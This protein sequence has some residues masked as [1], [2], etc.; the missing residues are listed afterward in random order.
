MFRSRESSTYRTEMGVH[1]EFIK[2]YS[3][4]KGNPP[5]EFTNVLKTKSLNL[6]TI[7]GDHTESCYMNTSKTLLL[8]ELG[9]EKPWVLE[10]RI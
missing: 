9:F 8:N 1:L 6:G 5:L 7:S 3:A 2:I 10:S 4:Q